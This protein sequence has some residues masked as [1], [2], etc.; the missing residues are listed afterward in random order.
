MTASPGHR[1]ARVLAT[2]A[3]SVLSRRGRER[4]S[5]AIF[6][7]LFTSVVLMLAAL[8]IDGGMAISQ[9]E[10]A[11]DVA[12]Q[13]ARK[14]SDDTDEEALRD[15][16]VVI[17]GGGCWEKAEQVAEAFGAGE[18]TSCHVDGG[19]E[20]TVGVRIH[21]RPVLLGLFTTRT[22]TATGSATAHPEAG[23]NTGGN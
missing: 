23:I 19:A 2:R 11:M 20:V 10:R 22:F 12:E 15:G 3:R 9:R 14:V 18:I 17:N 8:V 5:A 1:G 16:R 6:T 13:A 7:V 4:G 21:Y